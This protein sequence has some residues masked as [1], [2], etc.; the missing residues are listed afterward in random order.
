MYAQAF[1]E[2]CSGFPSVRFLMI[3]AG[4]CVHWVLMWLTEHSSSGAPVGLPHRTLGNKSAD[5]GYPKKQKGRGEWGARMGVCVY[6]CDWLYLW[7]RES[8]CYAVRKS[9]LCS[10]IVRWLNQKQQQ[11]KKKQY[12]MSNES[13]TAVQRHKYTRYMWRA[14]QFIWWIWKIK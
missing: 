3:W 6:V 8:T 7:V 5:E 13:Q 12:N 10:V 14:G 11:Q 4:L 1:S 9:T 2:F